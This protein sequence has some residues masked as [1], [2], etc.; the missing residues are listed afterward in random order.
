MA[1]ETSD[2]RARGGTGDRLLLIALALAWGINWPAIKLVLLEVSPWTFRFV[3]LGAGAIVMFVLVTLCG[4]SLRIPPGRPWLHV[5]IAGAL[6]VG[7]FSV[8]STLAM[9]DA[10]ASRVV[11]LVYT[12]PIWTSLVARF[13]LGERLTP[14]RLLSLALC[15]GGLAVLLAPHLPLPSGLWDALAT[16]WCWSAGTVYMKWAKIPADSMA[17]TA[18]QIVVG[19]VGIVGATIALGEPFIAWPV[20]TVTLL[21]WIYSSVIGVG[22]AYFMWFLIV[23]RLSAS[24]AGLAALLNPIVGVIGSAVLLNEPP[25]FNDMVGFALIFAAAA[26]VLLK[27]ADQLVAAR[28]K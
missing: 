5:I 14:L 12:M 11:I 16:A 4:R 20:Q 27:P 9:R 23:E 6:N 21:A 26:C 18:W 15:A 8:F 22:L 19:W 25:T 28:G 1:T 10:G 17:I 24:S 3:C 2:H 7:G 13:L